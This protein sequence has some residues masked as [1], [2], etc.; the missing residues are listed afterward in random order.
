MIFFQ[1]FQRLTCCFVN[2]YVT[3]L[4]IIVSN[5]IANPYAYGTCTA[6]SPSFNIYHNS[7]TI[8]FSQTRKLHHQRNEIISS[9]TIMNYS[10]WERLPWR[11]IWTRTSRCFSV[12][13]RLRRRW[14]RSLRWQR[15]RRRVC[16]GGLRF[17]WG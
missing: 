16:R 3:T 13:R 1:T 7:N 6:V 4:T 5:I 14:R 15:R 2:G 8:S 12:P 10:P 11:R 9:L 17:W